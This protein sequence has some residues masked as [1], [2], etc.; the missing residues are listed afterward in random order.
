MT[1]SESRPPETLRAWA[2]FAFS[3]AVAVVVA[4]TY[5]SLG[6]YSFAERG[7]AK[8]VSAAKNAATHKTAPVRKTD[9]AAADQYTQPRSGVAGAAR[10]QSSGVLGA[11][12]QS[13]TAP[14][15]TSGTSLP[16]TGFSLLSTAVVSIIFVIAGWA[17]RRRARLPAT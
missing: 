5:F 8:I 7:P 13:G 10:V 14:R 1:T 9:S 2:R 4:G 11:T 17:L 12:H 3:L 16:F 6:G 15:V